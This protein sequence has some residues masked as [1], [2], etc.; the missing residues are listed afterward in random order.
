MKLR[1]AGFIALAVFISAMGCGGGGGA[2][3]PKG[4]QPGSVLPP[5][6]STEPQGTSKSIV[7]DTPQGFALRLI[8]ENPDVLTGIRASLSMPGGRE[9]VTMGKVHWY[10]N[11][12]EVA[13]ENQQLPGT[14]YRR[15]DVVSAGAEIRRK[16]GEFILS[17]PAVTVQNALPDAVSADLS[18]LIPVVGDTVRVSAS[19]KDPD[20]D[21]VT[22]RYHWY[23]N[24]KLV[25][26]ETGDS[27]RVRKGMKGMWIQAEVQAFDGIAE[28]S[29]LQTPK[30]QVL[31]A[32]PV[33]DQVEVQG[34]GTKFTAVVRASDPDGDL[35][36]I[37]AKSLPSGVSLI[38]DTL[39]WDAA[40]VLP[41]TQ[42]PVVLRISD[43][44]GGE[45]EYSFRLSSDQ[46]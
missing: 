33:V 27:F 18:M 25:E 32:P 5:T 10:I 20:G 30:V 31:N 42:I 2:G 14:S 45:I 35:I 28:G 6:G 26:G 12:S 40:A 38:G 8:P 3:S 22:F 21:Q 46:K 9:K 34:D 16:E 7:P 37:L 39:R 19:G 1:T 13:L 15:G 29:R 17:A 43:G 41:G 24:D 36:A 44:D 4:G 23:A 11:G